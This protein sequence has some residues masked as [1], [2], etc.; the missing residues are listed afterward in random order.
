MNKNDQTKSLIILSA[1][2]GTQ[3]ESKSLIEGSQLTMDS[4]GKGPIKVYVCLRN[5]G[6][7]ELWPSRDEEEWQS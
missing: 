6:V 3:I 5:T 1:P 2:K 4:K 7:K